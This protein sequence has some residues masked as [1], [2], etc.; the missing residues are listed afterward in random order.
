MTAGH[1]VM[2]FSLTLSLSLSLFTLLTDLCPFLS[3]SLVLK[4]HIFVEIFWL[5]ISKWRQ[6]DISLLRLDDR[7][8]NSVL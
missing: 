4:K 2:I 5:Q 7:P 6:Y 1:R 3:L 8:D